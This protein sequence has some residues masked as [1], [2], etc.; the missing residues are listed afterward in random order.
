MAS[1][2]V[3][4]G[5]CGSGLEDLGLDLVVY[6]ARLHTLQ[7]EDASPEGSLHGVGATL[8]VA[9]LDEVSDNIWHICRKVFM[10]AIR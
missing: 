5:D 8:E 10:L 6:Q 2:A 7:H 9:S 3:K 1:N 4:G